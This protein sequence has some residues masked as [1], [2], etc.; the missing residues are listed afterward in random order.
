MVV[1]PLLVAEIEVEEVQRWR[2]SREDFY[3]IADLGIFGNKRVEWLEGEIFMA[4]PP[5]GEHSTRMDDLTELLILKARDQFVVRGQNGLICPR[6]EL[7]PDFALIRREEYQRNETPRSAEL[8]IEIAVSSLRYDRDDKS[9]HY[10]E[11]GVK[12]YWILDLA[13]RRILV[14]EE[15]VIEESRYRVM[16]TLTAAD[17]LTI[18]GTD[19]VLSGQALLG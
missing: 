4:P 19:V 12:H 2:V 17:S 18:P 7:A 14:F 1:E 9:E 10:A 6:A 15:P 16:R 11:A 8:V 3:R 5:G 13:R